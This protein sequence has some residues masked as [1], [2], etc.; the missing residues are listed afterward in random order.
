M[1]QGLSKPLSTEEQSHKSSTIWLARDQIDAIP[2]PPENIMAAMKTYKDGKASKMLGMTPKQLEQAKRKFFHQKYQ[3][4]LPRVDDFE[5]EDDE[6]DEDDGQEQL[7]L[8]IEEILD[9]V[10]LRKVRVEALERCLQ[11]ILATV[12]YCLVLIMQ[13]S[14]TDAFELESALKTQIDATAS[15]LSFPQLTNVNDV[16]TWMENSLIPGVI[17]PDTWYNGDELAPDDRGYSNFYNRQCGGFTLVQHRVE[18]RSSKAYTPFFKH[19]YPTVWV[20]LD[21]EAS[22]SLPLSGAGRGDSRHPFGPGH[23]PGKYVWT[24]DA[25]GE[26]QGGGFMVNFPPDST[27]ITRKLSELKS[28]LF[29]DKQTRRLLFIITI[30]NANLRLFAVMN[31]DVALNAAGR[32]ATEARLASL[33]M[34]NFVTFE[35]YVRV[36]LEI[37]LILLNVSH[38]AKEIV[39]LRFIG[40]RDYLNFWNTAGKLP[41][42]PAS[43]FP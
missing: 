9:R 14:L 43:S 42:G 22:T 23:D 1:Q 6:D 8:P 19:L 4:W 12:L 30:F 26:F 13:R 21:G 15:T 16:W 2:A 17:P 29:I 27:M 3:L 36:A 10:M 28:D 33:R 18:P 11:F 38:T 5:D 32:V 24:P 7:I 41:S 34:S 20:D 39:I 25:S 31:F 37:I 40:L 35:D